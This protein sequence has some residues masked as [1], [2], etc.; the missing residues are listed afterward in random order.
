MVIGILAVGM[1]IYEINSPASQS[2]PHLNANTTPATPLSEEEQ[3]RL[4][5]WYAFQD[6]AEHEIL[7]EAPQ[8]NILTTLQTQVETAMTQ[9][10]A[11][12]KRIQEIAIENE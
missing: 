5:E 1:L 9:L 10:N 12:T 2:N 7:R 8:K 4:E 3:L 6:K 11:I